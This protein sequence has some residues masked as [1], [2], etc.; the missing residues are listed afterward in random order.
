[1][2]DLTAYRLRRVCETALRIIRADETIDDKS[3][4]FTARRD[5]YMDIMHGKDI[6]IARI[7]EG[8]NW[9]NVIG[10]GCPE[11]EHYKCFDCKHCGGGDGEEC[12]C[13]KTGKISTYTAYACDEFEDDFYESNKIGD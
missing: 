9:L 7:G 12:L 11:V 4:Y 3:V 6:D 1:M 13:K 8:N 5:G 10:A 2:K